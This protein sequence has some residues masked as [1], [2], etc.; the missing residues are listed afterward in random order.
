MSNFNLNNTFSVFAGFG[1]FQYKHLESKLT[2]YMVV[3]LLPECEQ[4]QQGL[5][6]FREKWLSRLLESNTTLVHL[7]HYRKEEFYSAYF[8]ICLKCCP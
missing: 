7:H 1:R 8:C 6:W 4:L 2:G 3:N 5:A